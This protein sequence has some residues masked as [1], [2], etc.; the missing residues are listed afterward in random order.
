MEAPEGQMTQLVLAVAQCEFISK[1]SLRL[2][3]IEIYYSGD[4]NDEI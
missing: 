2:L 4:R 3:N 1:M